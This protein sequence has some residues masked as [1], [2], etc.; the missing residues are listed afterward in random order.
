[1]HLVPGIKI[2]DGIT[3]SKFSLQWQKIFT[4]VEL[5]I[6]PSTGIEDLCAVK[7]KLKHQVW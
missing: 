1:M 2:V 7:S 4:A 3:C 5:L 6:I